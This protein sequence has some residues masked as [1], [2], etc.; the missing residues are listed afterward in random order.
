VPVASGGGAGEE[1]EPQAVVV[2]IAI[3]NE[4]AAAAKRR[5]V[6]GPKGKFIRATCD[7][8]IRYPPWDCA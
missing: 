6:H 3:D 8:N 2:P 4:I 7:A 5:R 1:L